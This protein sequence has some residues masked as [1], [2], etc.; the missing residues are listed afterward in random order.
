MDGKFDS[1]DWFKADWWFE[2]NDIYGNVVHQE[3]EGAWSTGWEQREYTY[4]INV[5][6]IR[7]DGTICVWYDHGGDGA[8]DFLLGKLEIWTSV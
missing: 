8:D 5:D 2:I 4:T 3:T 6:A 1:G 7:D